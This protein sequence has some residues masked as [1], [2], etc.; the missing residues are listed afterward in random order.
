MY[1][2]LDDMP[3]VNARDQGSAHSIQLTAHSSVKEIYLLV[4]KL[5]AFLSY[6]GEQLARMF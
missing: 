3:P 2:Y 5:A 4:S 6:F 1:V